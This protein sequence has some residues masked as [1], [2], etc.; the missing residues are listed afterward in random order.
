MLDRIPEETFQEWRAYFNIDP[1]DDWR[2]DLQTGIIAS[3]VDAHRVQAK[4]A[5]PPSRYMPL[6]RV[7]K[8]KPV[9]RGEQV[10]KLNAF[11]A[12]WNRR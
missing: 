3:L 12:I 4:T 9:D 1:W 11:A 8:N 6:S 10:K 5:L 2:G 7:K